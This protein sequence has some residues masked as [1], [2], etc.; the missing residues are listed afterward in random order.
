MVFARY[1]LTF[2]LLPLSLCV[3]PLKMQASS[4]VDQ[5]HPL[6]L[7]TAPTEFG[8]ADGPAWDGWS[9]TIADPKNQA[10][11]RY[12]V[13]KKAFQKGPQGRRFSASFFNHGHVYV[14]DNAEG[15]ILRVESDR[16]LTTLHEED[17]EADNTR[18]PNDLVVDRSGGIFFTLTKAGEVVYLS[19]DGTAKT[20]ATGVETANGLIL[21][22]DES[23]LYVAEFLPKRIVAFDVGEAGALSHRRVFA[24]L[25]DGNPDLRGADGMTIDRAG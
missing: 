7:V 25:D 2:L 24:T 20:V 18:R 11:N 19:P 5:R 12:V 14:A 23:I 15:A 4:P 13:S 1:P 6:S 9:L 21:S 3:L 8:L 10:A 22:P 16:S 17:L